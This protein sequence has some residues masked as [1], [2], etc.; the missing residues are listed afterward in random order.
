VRIWLRPDI[1]RQHLLMLLAVASGAVMNRLASA[2]HRKA[3]LFN[4]MI[5]HARDQIEAQVRL[6][7]PGYLAARSRLEALKQEGKLDHESLLEFAQARKFDE[8]T[9]TLSLLSDLPVGLIERAIAQDRSEQILVLGRATGLDWHTT[10]ETL[11]MQAAFGCKHDLEQCHKSFA[12]LQ[13]ETARK[14]LIFY[15]LRE[16]AAMAPTR[17]QRAGAAG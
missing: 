6:R 16:E 1:P 15:R 14:A 7:S 5:A 9:I 17:H 12:K 13:P 10:R 3:D 11:Q 8:T 2:D 4:D